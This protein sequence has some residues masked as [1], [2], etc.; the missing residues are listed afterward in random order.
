MA[1]ITEKIALETVK[2]AAGFLAAA[3]APKIEKVKA[4]AVEKE[5]KG[6]L[7][8]D[9]LAKVMEVYLKKLSVRVS[10]ITSITFPQAKL[11]I[12]EAYEPLRM[13]EIPH[14]EKI[15]SNKKAFDELINNEA[16]LTSFLSP[17][18]KTFEAAELAT[19][20]NNSF[21]LIDGA[22]MGKST[23][24]KYV[25]AKILFKS[26][27]IPLLVELRNLDP[28]IGLF[29]HLA[30]ELDPLGKIFD[31]ELFYRLIEMGK[32]F[33]ILDGFDEIKIEY[34]SELAE[35]ISELSLKAGKNSLLVTS[36]PQEVL[37]ELTKSK[38]LRFSDF[39][40][41]Q[42]NSLIDRYDKISKTDIGKRLKK[43]I[44][45]VPERFIESPMLVSLLYRTFGINNSIAARISTFYDEIYDALYKG[46]DL[47]NKN[48]F[49][50]KKKSSLDFED[51]RKLLRALCHY[52]MIG[53][54]VSFQNW[55]EAIDSIEKSIEISRIRPS[56]AHNFLDDLIVAVPLMQRDGNE[57]K[58]YHKT[59]LEYFAAEYVIFNPGN[60]DLLRKILL[61]EL[62]ESYFSVFDFIFDINKA[63]YDEAI[64]F[65]F[66]QSAEKSVSK[67][68]GSITRQ[69]IN[70]LC[71]SEVG[72]WPLDIEEAGRAGRLSVNLARLQQDSKYSVSTWIEGTLY[73]VPYMIILSWAYVNDNLHK[74]AWEA[75]TDL[76]ETEL[77]AQGNIFNGLEEILPPRTWKSMRSL[78]LSES[79]KTQKILIDFLQSI[80]GI[81]GEQNID[82]R[83]LSNEKINSILTT[84]KR[85]KEL[86]AELK[87][88]I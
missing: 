36:R 67:Y 56:S 55:S 20:K 60:T 3:M 73:D 46:H 77:P 38:S 49:A 28:K 41:N 9:A 16:D 87:G 15:I 66:A 75:I 44:P 25:I 47:I 72:L 50:R 40:L 11:D 14:S 63:L 57:Y 86:N 59:I 31:R 61:S 48:G 34:Q 74:E 82:P 81:L 84:I 83:V 53:R 78:K 21:L 37:P 26:E 27:K 51:F 71:E 32:F 58:F 52:M 29:E 19:S 12:F 35:Q 39:T 2:P 80:T 76:V 88:F 42:A 45:E 62:A 79:D 85:Q 54:K 64:T 69:T 23:F 7:K 4:W 6:K 18:E 22:G 13:C 8:P 33:V 65:Y 24:S 17:E 68:Q 43:E 10:E 30:K 70:L 1:G 5:L